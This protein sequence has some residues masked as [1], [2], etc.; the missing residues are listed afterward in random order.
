MSFIGGPSA[1]V[2]KVN[3]HTRLVTLCEDLR[4]LLLFYCREWHVLDTV[5]NAV[6]QNKMLCHA[7][8]GRGEYKTAMHF[9]CMYKAKEQ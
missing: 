9:L 7:A 1:T 5:Q 6:W 3:C 4:L 2:N 8:P